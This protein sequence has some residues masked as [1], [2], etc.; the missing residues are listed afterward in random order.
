M[1][2]TLNGRLIGS[3]CDE[4]FEP[5]VGA[6]VRLVATTGLGAPSTD[7]RD[8]ASGV[9]DEATATKRSASSLGE[10]VVGD[11]GTFS[12]TLGSA[13]EGG[14]L[15]VD[16]YCGTMTGHRVP[17]KPLTVTLGSAGTPVAEGT[18]GISHSVVL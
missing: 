15:D 6:I 8:L 18:G 4:C 7:D 3:L 16:V 12:V 10:G 11:D 13:Y 5:L 9:R 17:P 14:H 2:Y 1:A